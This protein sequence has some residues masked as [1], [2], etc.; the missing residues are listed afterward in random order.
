M[1]YRLKC[2]PILMLFTFGVLSAGI[3]G[4]SKAPKTKEDDGKTDRVVKADKPDVLKKN[5]VGKPDDPPKKADFGRIA[6]PVDIPGQNKEPVDQPKTPVD[7][8]KEPADEPK[9]PV[10]K[11]PAPK[12]VNEEGIR[13]KEIAKQVAIAMQDTPKKDKDVG[14]DPK[15]DTKAPKTAPPVTEYLGHSFDEWKKKIH[16]SDPSVRETAMKAM[17]IFGPEKAYTAVPEILKELKKH[18]PGSPID[19][20]V[21]VNGTLTLSTIFKYT[22][23]PDPKYLKEAKPIYKAFLGNSQIILKIRAVQALPYLGPD[24]RD[25]IDDVIKVAKEPTTWEVRKEG[26]QVLTYLAFDEK[27]VPDKKVMPVLL[28]ALKNDKCAEV[29]SMALN[30]IAIVGRAIDPKD[31]AVVLIEVKR[32]CIND[33]NDHVKITAH[34]TVLTLEHNPK[35]E[36]L[37]K[38]LAAA[39]LVPIVNMAGTGPDPSVRLKALNAVATVG[40]LGK[41]WALPTIMKMMTDES[42]LNIAVNACMLLIPLRAYEAM[43]ALK[44]IVEDKKANEVLRDTAEDVYD[45][46]KLMKEFEEKE[47]NKKSTDKKTPDKK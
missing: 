18:T 17:L 15:K 25:L 8:P 1:R 13:A 31:K 38:G 9:E 27:G 14:K 6:D 47:K 35:N 28:Y 45:H 34:L 22:K 19:L 20:A 44:S 2:L 10:V 16:D 42:N 23:D 26:I 39:H 12:E 43:P 29:R 3:V 32:T 40:P 11:E 33:P 24:A 37:E 36:T 4:C 7:K 41:Q 5:D 21:A 30:S 46:L